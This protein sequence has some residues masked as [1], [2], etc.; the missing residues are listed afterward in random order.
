MVL[1]DKLT[2]CRGVSLHPLA[3]ED[4]HELVRNL[5]WRSAME[6]AIVYGLEGDG[7]LIEGFGRASFSSAM[8]FSVRYKGEVMAIIG[9]SRS[10]QLWGQFS[11]RAFEL[12]AIPRMIRCIPALMEYLNTSESVHCN[13]WEQSD[14]MIELMNVAGFRPEHEID[15]MGH[16]LIRFFYCGRDGLQGNE[17]APRPVAH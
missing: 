4:I 15:H 14:G 7:K 12:R 6:M 11:K 10:L 3:A 1:D 2:E 16:K 17:K 8:S 13:I 9:L 5:H